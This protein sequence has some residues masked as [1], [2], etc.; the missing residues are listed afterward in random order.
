MRHLRNRLAVRLTSCRERWRPVATV[1]CVALLAVACSGDDDPPPA[2]ASRGT[3]TSDDERSG[4]TPDDTRDSTTS[5]T[6]T[7][8]ADEQFDSVEEEIVDRYEGY[9][10]A[11]FAANSP[12]NPDDPGLREYATGAQL[13]HV[14]AETQ[15][16]LNA[17]VELRRPD[18]PA[19]FQEISV[20][21]VDGDR[22]VVQECVVNDG[23]VVETGTGTVVDDSVATYNVRGDMQRVDG[24]WRLATANQVQRWE[25]VAGCALAE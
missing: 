5:T 21:S 7:T 11:R 2:D 17:G 8:V 15:A 20:L 4:T 12:P 1:A 22:A 16:N 14:I 23:L 6:A 10:D 19:D 3:A 18:D 24:K 25:G 13:D 9:W